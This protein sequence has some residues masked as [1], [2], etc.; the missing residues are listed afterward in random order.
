MM[1]PDTLTGSLRDSVAIP[2]MDGSFSYGWLLLKMVVVLILIILVILV[3]SL[4]YRKWMVR[5]I[6]SGDERFTVLR[7]IPLGPGKSLMILRVFNDVFVV[8]QSQAGIVSLG[9]WSY[10]E[11][12]DQLVFDESGKSFFLDL[13]TRKI[14]K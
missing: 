5:G 3:I 10:D 11:I 6:V 14:S 9:R 13:L 7:E 12:R 1:R 4:F 2:A 8:L